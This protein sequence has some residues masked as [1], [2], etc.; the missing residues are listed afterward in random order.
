VVSIT[1]GFLLEITVMEQY[2]ALAEHILTNGTRKENRTGVDTIGV[3]GY[4]YKHDL[5]NGFPLLT[6]KAMKWEHIVIENLWFLSGATNIDFL[7]HYGVKFW[8]PWADEAGEVPSSY[9]NYWVRFP[10]HQKLSSFDGQTTGSIAAYNDQIKFALNELRTNPLSRRIVIS[11]WAPGNAQTSKLPPCHVTWV[12]NTQYDK[13]GELRLNLALLQ[14][15]CDVPLGV[16]YNLAGYSFLLHLMAHL[17]GL[18]VGEF[19]HT[20][21]DAHIYVDQIDGIKEQLK[22]EPRELPRLIID[23]SIKELKDIEALITEKPPLEKLLSLFRLEGYD[24]HP[25]I[26]FPVAV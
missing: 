11:A 25:A 5:N 4:F 12:L 13:Q 17:S 14:R 9:G 18:K 24:P 6:T 8:D 23:S 16:P 19:A 1:Q 22:R 21:V 15:S 3:F 10:V 7:R 20:L 2:L 26:K